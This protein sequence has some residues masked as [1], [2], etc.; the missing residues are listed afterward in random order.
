MVDK[1]KSTTKKGKPLKDNWQYAENVGGEMREVAKPKAK[2]KKPAYKAD[3]K[4]SIFE[5]TMRRAAHKKKN[6]E[7][8]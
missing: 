3:P 7:K 8:K 1:K 4:A 5:N 6:K 2:A